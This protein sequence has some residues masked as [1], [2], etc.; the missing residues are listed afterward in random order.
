MPV[1]ACIGLAVLDSVFFVESLPSG[2]HKHFATD[3]SSSGGGPAAVAAVTVARL[4]GD[5]R[6]LGRVGDD[7]AGTRI[8]GWLHAERVDTTRSRA[9]MAARSPVS[10]VFVDAVG[11]RMIVNHTDQALF[12]DETIDTGDVAGADAVLVDRHWPAGAATALAAANRLGI[13]GIADIDTAPHVGDAVL[14]TASHLV[15][16]SAALERLTGSGAAEGLSALRSRTDAF[17]A[18]TRGADG[19]DWQSGGADGHIDA[20]SVTAANTLGAGDVFHG[21]FALSLAETGDEQEALEFASAA[22]A[23]KVR[24]ATIPDRSAVTAIRGGIS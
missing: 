2:P 21:A 19:V 12:A 15:F 13:P 10:S 17:L 3:R 18:V 20:I 5:A 9:V 14:E 11:E 4:G 8:L 22:A 24:D 1:V 23:V 16:A 6:F 7:A